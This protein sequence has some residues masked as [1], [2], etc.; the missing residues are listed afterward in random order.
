[1][2]P[3]PDEDTERAPLT[4]RGDPP[5]GAA[6]WSGSGPRGASNRCGCCVCAGGGGADSEYECCRGGGG[7]FAAA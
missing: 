5:A 6:G 3:I 7:V 2:Y 4:H 1:M